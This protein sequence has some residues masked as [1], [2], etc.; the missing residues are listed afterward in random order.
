VII[1]ENAKQVNCQHSWQWNG[2]WDGVDSKTKKPIGGP[3]AKCVLCGKKTFMR[4]E[5]WGK[6]NRLKEENKIR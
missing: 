2:F 4:W 6:L 5:E 3:I 1:L